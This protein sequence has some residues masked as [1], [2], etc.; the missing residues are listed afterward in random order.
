M[1]TGGSSFVETSGWRRLRAVL[2]PAAFS[3]ELEK[4]I[5]KATQFNALL[6]KAAIQERIQASKYAANAPLTIIIK[7]SS[8]PLVGLGARLFRAITY[9]M[10]DS[11]TAFV[12]AIRKGG[13]VDAVNLIETLHQGATIPVTPAMRGMFFFLWKLTTGTMNPARAEGRVKEIYEQI[14]G[15]GKIIYPLRDT[16]TAIHIP[17]R[18]FMKDVFEDASLAAAMRA[19]WDKAVAAAINK[20]GG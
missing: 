19:N 18:P 13:D 9:K 5:R 12:G 7:G 3:S 20:V 16:T 1:P 2:S 14:E 17:P 4:N 15:T 6:A 11:Y 10:V 8:K